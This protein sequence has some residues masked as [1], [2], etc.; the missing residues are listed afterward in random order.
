MRVKKMKSSDGKKLVLA[1]LVL[2]A[3]AL[4]RPTAAALVRPIRFE[5]LSLEEGLSQAAVMD[6]MQDRRGYIWLATED[7]LNRYDGTAFKVYRHD[8]ADPGTLPDNFI[9][10]LDQDAGGNVWIA[11]RGGLCMWDRTTDRIVRQETPG[12]RNI[13]VLQYQA[14]GNVL[15]IGTRESDLLKLEIGTGAL[16]RFA[17]DATDATT[18]VDDRVYALYV[19]AK[20]RLWVGTEAGLDLRDADGTGFTHQL[21]SG[22]DAAGGGTAKIRAILADDMGGLWIGSAGGGLDRL[23]LASGRVRRFRHDAAVPGSLAKTTC[24]PSCRTR[25]AGSGSAPAAGST[26]TIPIAAPSRTT[27]RTHGT[28]AASPTTTSCPWPRTGA[29]CSGWERAWAACTSGTP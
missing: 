3:S 4:P 18:L 26:S 6:V 11:T 15:W 20:D 17:H 29:A 12:V 2:A 9:W 19:D 16:R 22:W 7:G 24:A 21:T 27:A 13:R 14:R 23:D 8:V 28:P 5:Q 25:G 10:D 1:L